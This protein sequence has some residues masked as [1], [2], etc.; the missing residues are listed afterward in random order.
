MWFPA[1]VCKHVFENIF[2][3]KIN[4]SKNEFE[5][6]MADYVGDFESTE[7]TNLKR[8]REDQEMSIHRL[9]EK[10]KEKLDEWA[11]DDEEIDT[12]VD[13]EFSAVI[14]RVEDGFEEPT[15]IA[16]VYSDKHLEAIDEILDTGF[17]EDEKEEE[18]GMVKGFNKRLQMF[19]G[20]Y[21]PFYV[22]NDDALK[23]LKNE[24]KFSY[25]YDL[26]LGFGLHT[27]K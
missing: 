17:A 6:M 21:G 26:K 4:K 1:I 16:D 2:E 7:G 27:M 8:E 14:R 15:H 3:E 19:T 11:E 10:V 20:N 5:E 22:D 13:I 9:R 23:D 25:Y 24:F 12:D 18:S